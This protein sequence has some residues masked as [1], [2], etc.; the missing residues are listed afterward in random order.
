MKC[1]VLTSGSASRCVPLSKI[2]GIE[3]DYGDVIDGEEQWTVYVRYIHSPGWYEFY[4]SY[5]VA[6]ARFNELV[7]ILEGNDNG[8]N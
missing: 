1:L 6:I 7:A 8:E 4:N 2:E 3:L 5:A